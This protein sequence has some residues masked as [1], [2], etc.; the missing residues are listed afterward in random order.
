MI[1]DPGD[2]KW[3]AHVAVWPLPNQL[4]MDMEEW[5]YDHAE[6]DWCYTFG[7]MCFVSKKDATM[8]KLKFGG[9]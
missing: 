5:L 7:T 9:T 6:D 8:F 4:F 1:K 3:N 2:A